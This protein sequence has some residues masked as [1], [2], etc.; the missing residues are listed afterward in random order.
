MYYKKE[1]HLPTLL[2]SHAG[3]LLSDLIKYFPSS[4]KVGLG[5]GAAGREH[6]RYLTDYI[7]KNYKEEISLKSLA[8]HSY[9][10][11][12]YLS[13]LFKKQLGQT[14]TSYVLDAKPW[15][16]L[17]NVPSVLA[18]NVT[19]IKPGLPMPFPPKDPSEWLKLIEELIL[20]LVDKFGES[21][22]ESWI[23][24]PYFSIIFQQYTDST[25][26][27]YWEIYRDC[28]QLLRSILPKI[29][30]AGV[31][32][33]IED[34]PL[35]KW[36]LEKCLEENVLPD[37]LT[38]QSFNTINP[39]EEDAG[40][41]LLAESEAM[42]KA[43]SEKED[44]ISYYLHQQKKVM[45]NLGITNLSIVLSEWN[46]TIWQRDLCNDTSY[47]SAYIF[48]NILENYDE[49]EGMGYWSLGDNIEELLPSELLFHGGFGLFTRNSLPKAAYR[50]F[51]LLNKMGDTF[52]EQGKGYFITRDRDRVQVYLYNYAHYDTLYRYR[53]TTHMT[54]TDRY[55]VFNACQPKQYSILL[56]GLDSGQY[57]IHQYTVGCSGGSAYDAWVKMGA[58][59]SYSKDYTKIE[60]LCYAFS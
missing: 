31:T 29:K 14:F 34:I 24:T 39:S 42:A 35:N 10:S 27:E 37:I 50:A 19:D 25:E 59:E 45:E 52:I 54:V 16:E 15:I 5:T 30:I 26:D 51:E 40:L 9:L 13:R 36:F 46:S 38:M 43:T 60:E 41:A 32:A 58:P 53:H 21:T 3:I 17:N 6:L 57:N 2:R 18:R 1:S 44:Y 28:V 55:T 49:L 48:K 8:E 20:H 33:F 11:D 4:K 7:Q 47:K 56:K 22:V 12:S 23:F